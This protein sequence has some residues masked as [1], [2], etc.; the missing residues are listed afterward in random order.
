MAEASTLMY[1]TLQTE[2][3]DFILSGHIDL[4]ATSPTINSETTSKSFRIDLNNIS[5][6]ANEDLIVYFLMPP[7]D[8]R[9][10][11][12]NAVI[13]KDNGYYQEIPL[14]G[15]KIKIVTTHPDTSYS[16]EGDPDRPTSI[17]IT[18]PDLF[19]KASKCLVIMVN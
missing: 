12:L 8:L 14:T 15:K 3:N 10:K 7:V 6:E 16:L 17:R 18:N 1:V 9:N 5:V 4:T 11:P 13:L 19:W 2:E